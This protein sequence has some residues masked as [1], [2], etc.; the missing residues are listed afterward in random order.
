MA[1]LRFPDRLRNRTVLIW[2]VAVPLTAAVTLSVEASYLIRIA[3]A[4][5]AAAV[6][7]RAG[8]RHRDGLGRARLLFASSLAAGAVSGITAAGYLLVTGAVAPT[9]WLDD[10]LY[11]GYVPLAVL[12]VLALPRRS[13]G[14]GGTVQALADGAV[15]AGSLWYLTMVLLIDPWGIGQDLAPAAQVVTLSYPLAPAFVIAVILSALPRVAPR[16]RPFLVRAASGVAMLG[17]ADAAFAVVAW[18]G[19]YS[20]ASWVAALSELGLLLLLDAA[21]LGAAPQRASSQP[22]ADGT[23]E[24]DADVAATRGALVVGA[25][26]APLGL[27]CAA[28][29][30]E[31]LAG[32]DVPPSQFWPILAIGCAVVVRHLTNARETGR[33]VARIAAREKAA[34]VQARTDALTGLANR[35]A[36][37][38]PVGRRPPRPGLPSGRGRTARPQRLQGRQRHPRPRHRRRD[39]RAHGRP[40]APRRA[41][42]QH[43]AARW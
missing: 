8:F 36:F 15:A 18:A 34:Q 9:G 19:D 23:S 7:F 2:C 22:E 40:V 14:R 42:R 35:T 10:W 28:A 6:L 33:L 13:T 27:A 32:H 11:L 29:L 38:A 12:G 4:V 20:P 37:V 39:P 41:R 1:R 21:L 16:A 30:R 43:R 31:L 3:T 25:P 26:F 24:F 5:L 17:L